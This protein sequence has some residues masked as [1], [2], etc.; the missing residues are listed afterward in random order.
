MTPP[1]P[2]QPVPLPNHYLEEVFPGIQDQIEGPEYF[3]DMQC[4]NK[5]KFPSYCGT[6]SALC[7]T[8]V[9]QMW[10]ILFWPRTQFHSKN[11]T[12]LYS[13]ACLLSSLSIAALHFW[14]SHHVV[15]LGPHDVLKIQRS[16]ESH[17]TI[18]I[19]VVSQP[20]ASHQRM[21]EQQNSVKV[22]SLPDSTNWNE[23][24]CAPH[25]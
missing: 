15:C 20:D 19:T 4:S 23:G 24:S 18:Y 12:L 1:P 3:L 17:S 16:C 21:R 9:K 5:Y 7:C 8:A 6:S 22:H 14:E 2:G 11:S 10:A 25:G 13:F